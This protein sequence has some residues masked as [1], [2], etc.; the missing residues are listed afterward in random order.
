MTGYLVPG[1]N[2]S[3]RL[4]HSFLIAIAAP[5]CP[6]LAMAFADKL[7]LTWQRLGAA[8]EGGV[9]GLIGC[10]MLAVVLSIGIVRPRTKGRELV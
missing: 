3:G 5:F 10:A 6:L 7:E 9:F 2:L 8:F 4:P 1:T